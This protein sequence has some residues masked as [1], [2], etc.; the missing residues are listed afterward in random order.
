MKANLITILL[1]ALLS[2]FVTNANANV[3][4]DVIKGHFNDIKSRFADDLV[5]EG[6]VLRHGIFN[7][8]ARG[9]DA[10]HNGSGSVTAR[11]ADGER[12]VQLEADFDSTPGPDYYVYSSST[13][14]IQT[15]ED[16][17]NASNVVEL[18][19]LL[20]GSGASFYDVPSDSV[21]LSSITIICKRFHV[22]ITSADMI[23]GEQL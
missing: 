18:G 17:E 4:T 2:S 10:F 21:S 23:I 12:F 20:K 5:K 3:F 7:E 1:L 13:Q 11:T 9:S 8:D 15:I 6:D 19:K 16:F 14:D 22:F